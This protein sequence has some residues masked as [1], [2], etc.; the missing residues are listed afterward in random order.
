MKKICL[1]CLIISMVFTICSCSDDL[2]P[3]MSFDGYTIIYKGHKYIRQDGTDFWKYY[4]DTDGLPNE[5]GQRIGITPSMK[6]IW[7]ICSDEL[8]DNVLRV[9]SPGC[10]ISYYFKEGFVFPKHNEVALSRI[11]LEDVVIE[12]SKDEDV[13]WSDIIDYNTIIP[14]ANYEES[15]IFTCYGDLRDYSITFYTGAF[16]VM[17]LEDVVYIGVARDILSGDNEVYYKIS[18][19]YQQIFKDKI[20]EYY[21]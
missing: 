12:L 16:W 14:Y 20:N 21:K 6:T 19:D 3:R 4:Y 1:I 2:Y 8:D 17:L 9:Y 5:D 18:D 11:L 13:T 15:D 10:Y 7:L